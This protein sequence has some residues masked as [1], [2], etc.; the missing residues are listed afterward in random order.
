MY[1]ITKQPCIKCGEACRKK[2]NETYEQS[3]EYQTLKS[4]I[5]DELKTNP[6]NGWPDEHP[7]GFLLGM[8]KIFVAK[9]KHEFLD[10]K[11]KCFQCNAEISGADYEKYL[12]DARNRP[13]LKKPRPEYAG[14]FNDCGWRVMP[15]LEQF[16]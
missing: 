14:I 7:D 15:P 1:W 4:L 9:K 12:E 6:S 5:L 16:L 3:K 2:F 10:Y 8:V 11:M 13:V